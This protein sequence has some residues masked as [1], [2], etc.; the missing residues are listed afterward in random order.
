LLAT[1][2]N[3]RLYVVL[4]ISSKVESADPFGTIDLVPEQTDGVGANS[5]KGWMLANV[6]TEPN[7][8]RKPYPFRSDMGKVLPWWDAVEAKRSGPTIDV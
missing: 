7:Q 4:N 2:N 1:P 8:T 6:R 3:H 5:H